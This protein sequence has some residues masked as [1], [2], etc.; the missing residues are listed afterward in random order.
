MRPFLL[1]PRQRRSGTSQRAI[2]FL[3]LEYRQL[4]VALLCLIK[5]R[6]TLELSGMSPKFGHATTA[7]PAL[8]FGD[9]VF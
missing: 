3:Q 5:C 7:A 2:C 8:S 6:A 4:G 1:P 9:R